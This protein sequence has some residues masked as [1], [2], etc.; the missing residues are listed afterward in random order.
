MRAQ[1]R[2]GF[3]LIEA[4][5]AVSLLGSL[6]YLGSEAFRQMA[7]RYCLEK[8][9][10][11]VRSALNS[12]R[13]RALTEGA[14]F[15]FRFAGQAYTLE[16]YDAETKTWLLAGKT[17]LEK[18]SVAA[19]NTPV[20]TSDG[21][22]TGLATIAIANDWGEYRLTLAITGRIKTARTR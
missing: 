21:T 15:R 3:T 1:R 19:N 4:L 17:T 6:V 16:R 11:D 20:F 12:A 2:S 8:A 22:V 7:P 13:F 18:V 10:W 5:V 9:V 14:S